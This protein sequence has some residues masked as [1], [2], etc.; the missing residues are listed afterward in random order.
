MFERLKA[1]RK[2]GAEQFTQAETGLGFTLLDFWR[3]SSSDL[4]GNALR[5]H[6]AE[7]LVARALGVDG[8]IRN[9]WDPFDVATASN[10]RIEVKS[11][12]YLQS[13][14]QHAESAI[15]FDIRETLAWAADTNAFSPEGERKRQADVYVFALLAHRTKTTLNPLDVSQWE[16]YLLPASILNEHVKKQRRISLGR[17]IALNAVRC[18]YADLKRLIEG[19]ERAD[20]VN[21]A[22]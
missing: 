2:S 16:F 8:D 21:P 6:V 9:E 20:G 7:F 15:S 1:T 18:F 17:L 5:G 3:W 10:L 4:V 12:A 14:A 13:W 22:I 19:M 11:C